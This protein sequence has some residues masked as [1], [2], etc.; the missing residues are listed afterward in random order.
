MQSTSKALGRGFVPGTGKVS[1]EIAIVG[2][3]VGKYELQTGLPFTGPAGDLLDEALDSAG[4]NRSDCWLTNV[5]KYQPMHELKLKGWDD[6]ESIENLWKE[7]E[8][9]NPKKILALGNIPLYF[10]TGKQGIADYRGSILKS[11]R[12]NKIVVPTFNPAHLLYNTGGEISA[13]YQ[14]FLIDFD[15]KKLKNLR[16]PWHQ[17]YRNLHIAKNSC[18]L[19]NFLSKQRTLEVAVDIEV[20]K[21]MPACIAF[22]FDKREA[23]SVP[24]FQELNGIKICTIPK[25][26]LIEIWRLVD[27]ALRCNRVIGQNFKFDQE[28]IEQEL[29]FKV[30]NFYA[31]TML[32][33]YVLNPELPKSIAFLASLHTEEPFWKNEGKEFNPRRDD[34]SQFLLYNAKDAAVTKEVF[35]VQLKDLEEEGLKEYY[36]NYYHKLHK[37]YYD[38]E[39]IGLNVDEE[40]RKVLIKKYQSQL[41][42]VNDELCTLL[43]WLPNGNSPKDMALLV[44]EE[45]RLPRRESLD[46][47]TLV[48]LM[49]NVA[50]RDEQKRVL[51]L[52]INQRRLKKILGPDKL[53]FDVD[54]DGKARTNYRIAGTETGRSSTSV[55]KAP[56]RNGKI[57]LPFQTMSKHGDVGQDF[58]SMFVPPPGY[59]F[60]NCDQSQAEARIVALLAEDY[61][62]LELFDSGID[63]HKL[64]YAITSDSQITRRY[65]TIRQC[66][67]N[68][69][70]VIKAITPIGKNER[71]TAKKVRHGFNLAMKKHVL[72]ISINTDAR[73]FGFDVNISEWR[74]GKYIEALDKFTPKVETVFHKQIRDQLINTRT[75]VRPDGSSRM[76]YERIG[77]DLFKEGYADI[78]QHTVAN[79]TKRAGLKLKDWNPDL[80]IVLEA[81]DAL[82]VQAEE[83]D[84]EMIARKMA[85]CMSS[86]IDFE[87]CSLKRGKI[88]IP[89][90]V[91]MGR[92]YS[93]LEKVKL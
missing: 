68:R 29:C 86:E 15:V 25:Q 5:I 10:L 11:S 82:L 67:D 91:E 46:E 71:F 93:D 87:R 64:T 22:S 33:A 17:P 85:E 30:S 7:L 24:L 36:F 56:I 19:L 40:Q 88:K 37:F 14:K 89:A 61:D 54:H 35:D 48:A 26:D 74:A 4:I 18:D 27:K 51:Q 32:M 50:K 31:D 49:S 60:I 65:P 76:F 83:K 80:Q 57:G 72:M 70:E 21:C 34:I 81:H 77:N 23:I 8:Q 20:I 84:A 73:R 38:M 63:V 3:S 62:L 59:V 41:E 92:N 75:L 53:L 6:H 42:A 69:D 13:Y 28:R 47:D 78:P 90:D 1:P 43:S 58:R 9:I 2:Q 45:L 79:Q 55:L 44:Y 12:L 39:L 52:I 16:L 66:L